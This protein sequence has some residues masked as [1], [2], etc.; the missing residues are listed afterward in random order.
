ME[1]KV[2]Y[3]GRFQIIGNDNVDFLVLP[4]FAKDT[5]PAFELI[6]NIEAIRCDD[7]RK[8]YVDCDGNCI[9]INADLPDKSREMSYII[10]YDDA[11]EGEYMIYMILSRE[12][13]SPDTFEKC[14]MLY[15][16]IPRWSDVIGKNDAKI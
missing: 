10:E 7:I 13:I 14:R 6:D 1:I 3:G 16:H 11:G 8:A 9:H 2:N 15:P 4:R 12:G 5:I